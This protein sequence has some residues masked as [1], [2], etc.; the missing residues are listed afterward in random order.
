M[1]LEQWSL[2]QLVAVIGTTVL[3]AL[4]V[5]SGSY[6]AYTTSTTAG[7]A[8]SERAE[9]LACAVAA[10]AVN[11]LLMG[12]RLALHGVLRKGVSGE[13]EAR[14]IC[15]TDQEGQVLAH[16][17][18]NGFPVA[19]QRVWERAGDEPV[20]F[21]TAG[22]PLMDVGM[23]IKEGQ[24]GVVHVGM[25]RLNARQAAHRMAWVMSVALF[26]ALALVFAGA[27][28]VAVK[29]SRPLQELEAEVSRFPE[30]RR[31][32]ALEHV[33][34]TREVRRLS[35]GFSQMVDRMEALE[36]ERS[37]TQERMVNAERLA[38]LGEMAAG[39]AHE[40]LNP[41]D[42][43]QECLTYLEADPQKGERAAKYYPMLQ[44][45]LERIATAMR[46]MLTFA[47]SGQEVRLEKY[48]LAEA[49]ASVKMLVESHLEGR[50]VRLTWR[51][52][53]PCVCLCDRRGLSQA[54]LNLVLNASEA[55]EQSEEP[56]VLIEGTCDTEWVYLAV[57]DNGPGVPEEF[58]ERV[59]E[60]FFTTKP[61]DEGTGL[62]LSVSRQLMRAAGGDLQ[63]AS[64]AERL[65]GARFV[66]RLRKATAESY[67]V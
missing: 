43:M 53:G 63:L 29:A 47:R 55:A 40:I 19:L 59:F 35:R 58:C 37:A 48:A 30:V 20:R 22:R 5:P 7:R 24:L 17:F 27:H 38:A 12:D 28:M 2:D 18:E 13:P 11:P 16:T 3:L 33:S 67:D 65:E 52:T 14:Y 36:Q 25:S 4:F 41:L 32:A 56:E 31:R 50:R 21:R 64:E 26:I 60:P 44:E 57:E 49:I 1:A 61:V 23:P 66:I 10:Q 62:G 34:G 45:G 15:V 54:L 6:F 51:S 39:L 42:G 46:G 9:S 8:L